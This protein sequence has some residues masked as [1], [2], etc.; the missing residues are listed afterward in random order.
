MDRAVSSGVRAPRSSPIGD[1]SRASSRSPTPA[2]R[3]RRCRSAWVRREP[4]APT[5]ATGITSASVSR[6][7]SNLASWVRTHSTVRPSAT[8]V[9]R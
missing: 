6:G 4:I 1:L 3:S 7:T 9:R 8:A 5:N 2:S